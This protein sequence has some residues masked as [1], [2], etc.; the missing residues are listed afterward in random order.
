M[1]CMKKKICIVVSSMMTVKVFLL[2]H[3]AALSQKYN[4]SVVA[5]TNDMDFFNDAGIKATLI[6]I[7]I[8]R[9][10]SLWHDLKALFKLFCLFRKRRFDVVHSVTPKAG[11]LT[12][13]AGI[14]SNVP[15]RIHI[16]TGQVWV[17]RS[18]IVRW[19]LKTVD[20]LF[21][22]LATDVLV[23]SFSQQNFL[24]K[25]NVIT[26]NK[27]RVLAKGSISGVDTVRFRPDASVRK[28]IR[29]KEK[30]FDSEIVFLYLGRLNKDK[31]LLDLAIAFSTLCSDYGHIHLMVVG[32]D[33][34][35]IR[36]RMENICASCMDR[37]HFIDYTSVPEQYMVAADVFCL[38]SY[39]EG[40]GST[41]IE[42]ACIGIPAIGSRIYG[43][44]DAIDEDITGLLYEVGNAEELVGRMK[45]FIN[46]P[47]LIKK[48]GE[49]ARIRAQRHFSKEKVTSAML[50]YYEEKLTLAD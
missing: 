23:D 20:W 35:N 45:Q 31:G 46:V 21:V 28:Q 36:P 24:I 13:I 17:T 1:C 26:A 40:F 30:I 4:V 16:F 33:E 9:K 2:D 3:I 19:L 10:I 37:I 6:P 43:I 47:I 32:P 22:S 15:I 34:E 38:P 41:I 50:E 29:E 8:E 14:L 18:G 25:E 27:S 48:M 12:M 44:T 42:T 7:R 5:N 11:L 49:A 39:R